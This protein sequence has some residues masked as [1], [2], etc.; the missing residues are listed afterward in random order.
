MY[1]NP[2]AIK[3][4]RER[5]GPQDKFGYKDG[6]PLFTAEK[7]DPDGWADL[8]KEAGARYVIPSAEHHDGFS[9]QDSA[10]NRY[11]AKRMGPKRVTPLGQR[12]PLPFRQHEGALV[13]DFPPTPAGEYAHAVTMDGLKLRG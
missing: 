5:Y 11:N 9:L 1:G 3:W 6:I 2:D 4:H 13:I 7:W 8:F 12:R 10:I